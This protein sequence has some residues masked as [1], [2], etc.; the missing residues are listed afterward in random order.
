MDKHWKFQ[1]IQKQIETLT[2]NETAQFEIR[3][4]LE[5][6]FVDLTVQVEKF[7]SNAPDVKIK[8]DT[9]L[10]V[11]TEASWWNIL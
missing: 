9:N 10:M 5:D 4:V 7:I 1:T 3:E 2:E 6:R 8:L 11:S